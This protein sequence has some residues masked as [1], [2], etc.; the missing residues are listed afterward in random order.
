MPEEQG[1][2]GADVVDVFIAIDVKDVGAL[3]VIDIKGGEAYRAEGTYGAI[4]PARDIL[5]GPLKERSRRVYSS[6]AIY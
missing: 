4:D 5:R 6:H 2:P 1:P 3:A